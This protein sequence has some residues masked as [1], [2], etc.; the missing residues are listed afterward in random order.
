[1]RGNRPERQ[2]A[3]L[4]LQSRA[5]AVHLASTAM[6]GQAG[7]FGQGQNIAGFA[8]NFQRLSNSFSFSAIAGNLARKRRQPYNIAGLDAFESLVEILS[9]KMAWRQCA[10]TSYFIWTRNGTW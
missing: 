1:M 2:I 6:H 8:H 9:G 4:R 10:P 7:R 5:D 3:E